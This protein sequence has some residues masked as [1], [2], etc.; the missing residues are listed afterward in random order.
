MSIERRSNGFVLICDSCGTEVKYFDA[1]MEAVDYKKSEGWRSVK[2]GD[3]W[4][5][6]CDE[7][8]DD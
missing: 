2:N 3:E 8:H 7:C 4:E 6:T 5:D 1:F